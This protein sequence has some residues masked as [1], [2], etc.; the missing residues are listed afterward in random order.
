MIKTKLRLT[1][2][3]LAIILLATGVSSF[4]LISRIGDDVI[5]LADVATPMQEAVLNLNKILLEGSHDIEAF[6]RKKEAIAKKGWE[7]KRV[8]FDESIAKYNR[9]TDTMA[10]KELGVEI[11]KEYAIFFSI[12]DQVVSLTELQFEKLT[13]FRE[14]I[15]SINEIKNEELKPFL[16]KSKL[17][18]LLTPSQV[19]MEKRL[20]AFLQ[21]ELSINRT[22]A[23]IQSYLL[24]REPSKRQEASSGLSGFQ[25]S[26]ANYRMVELSKKEKG[27]LDAITKAFAKTALT[28]TE[29]IDLEDQKVA[30][31]ESF[32]KAFDS[33]ESVL[34]KKIHPV[35]AEKVSIAR[36]HA[37]EASVASRTLLFVAAIIG[38]IGGVGALVITRR[39]VSS[40]Q[41]LAHGAKKIGEGDLEFRIEV[42]SG[43]EIGRL[44][45]A[46]NDMTVARK[47]AEEDIQIVG[48]KYHTLFEYAQDG[49]VIFDPDSRQIIEANEMAA[50][51]LG[52]TSDEFHALKIDEYMKVG[53][54]LEQ[55]AN[56]IKIMN[57]QSALFEES[58]RRK[59]GSLMPVEVSAKL[60]SYYGRMVV[61]MVVR[62]ITARKKADEELKLAAKVF[63]SSSEG[64]IVTD[65]NA[66]IQSIN[67]AFAAITGYSA[68]EAIGK[69]A[70][71]LKSDRQN[72]TFYQRMWEALHK[73]GLWHGEIWNRRKDGEV[74]PESLSI[75][76]IKDESGKTVQY[77][78][79]FTDITELK[80]SQDE[81]KHQAFHDSLTGLPNRN[82]FQ[83]RLDVAL[84]HAH[85]SGGRLAVMFIDLDNF[86]HINDSLGHATGD[87]FLKRVANILSECL[88]EDDSV[89]RVGGDEFVIIVEHIFSE[90]DPINVAKRII[91][92]LSSAIVIDGRDLYV[93]A[94]IG[95]TYYPEDGDDAETLIKNADMAMYR[96]KEAGKNNFQLFTPTM[97][98]RAVRRLELE[99]NLRKALERDEIFVNYQPLVDIRSNRI[100]G[101]EAL[102]RWRVED[103]VISPVEFIPVAEDSGLIVELGAWI[104]RQ[105]CIQTEKWRADGFDIFASVNLSARQLEHKMLIESVKAILGESGL[106]P[107]NL[108]LEVTESAVMGNVEKAIDIMAKIS[109]LGIRISIDD[110]GTGYSS[111]SYL[112]KFPI[113]KL[114]ID[115]SFVMDIPDSKDDCA[116]TQTVISMGHSL[117]L[118]VIA[119]GVET[120]EQLNFLN[121]RGC[122]QGQGYYYSKPVSAEE[123]TVLLQKNQELSN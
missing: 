15:K 4:Y 18:V 97:N 71:L 92:K 102:M 94:S 66:I 14:E 68:K 120:I 87:Q 69:P 118:K 74:Y 34:I 119:E 46:F 89:A 13:L 1:V 47:T 12:G 61:Q 107:E 52:Y 122:N 7:E 105:A 104:L 98:E 22:F 38:L 19:A 84:S 36:D 70:S 95:V 20:K 54:D 31:L 26:I 86:K 28:A 49:I 24:L 11:K 41:E 10:L 58:H 2:G 100:I 76:A 80:Q 96:A 39:I 73:T 56:Y 45:G 3:L 101:M 109:Q 67:P 75:S 27:A 81:L 9:L 23:A 55:D 43:D 35:I 42:K 48:E 8:R 123:F 108:E 116:I 33:V 83:D 113:H 32:E 65:E 51:K 5:R 6:A 79:V 44:A 85:R 110:F 30:M 60:F 90:Q 93:G 77:A 57:G 111:L 82:L 99:S 103:K 115:R 78:G 72:S 91:Q 25:R 121:E 64:V 112:K 37:T 21:M 117:G 17:G 40:L 50:S 114:K 88:R 29:I 59:D 63:E 106:A 53:F 62:D 16:S